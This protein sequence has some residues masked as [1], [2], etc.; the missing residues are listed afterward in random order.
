MDLTKK[1]NVGLGLRFDS[2]ISQNS[3]PQLS[4][5][6]NR[7]LAEGELQYKFDNF[8]GT[9]NYFYGTFD[10]GIGWA[11]SNISGTTSSGIAFL[12][13]G[14]RF[15]V[16]FTLS[17]KNS[18]VAEFALENLLSSQKFQDGTRQDTG[19]LDIKLSLGFKF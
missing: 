1:L 13:P 12:L 14:I 15:G 18:M 3:G 2:D 5:P 9:N 4:V 19:E 17:T 8:S 7:V 10:L 16:N 6:T 11:D